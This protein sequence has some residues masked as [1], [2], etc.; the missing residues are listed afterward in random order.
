MGKACPELL[1]RN[2]RALQ[3]ASAPTQKLSMF[4]HTFGSALVGSNPYAN[5]VA[6]TRVS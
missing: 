6:A 4:A 1:T 5:T 2:L 3:C